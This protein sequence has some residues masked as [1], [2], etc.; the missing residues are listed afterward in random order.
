MTYF[1]IDFPIVHGFFEVEYLICKI[2]YQ[3]ESLYSNWSQIRADYLVHHITAGLNVYCSVY[4][5]E[6]FHKQLFSC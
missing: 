5:E 1:Q 6:R 3:Y 2:Y 4:T